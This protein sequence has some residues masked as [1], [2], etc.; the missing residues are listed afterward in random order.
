MGKM[1]LSVGMPRAG[2]GWYYNLTQDLIIAEGGID[3]KEIRSKYNLKRLLTEVNCNLGTLSFYRLIPALM[4]I[5]F[6]PSYV[7]KLH[8]E[9]RPLADLFIKL[10]VIKPTYIYRDPRDA[11]LSAYEYGQRMSKK[12]LQ[13]AFTPLTTIEKAIEFMT[14][15]I[16][17]ATG[18]LNSKQTLSVKYEELKQNYHHE[19]SRLGDFMSID[20]TRD[21]VK[22]VI[23]KYQPGDKPQHHPGLHFVKGTVGRHKE[24]FTESQLALCEQYFGAFLSEHGYDG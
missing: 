10:G 1:I 24:F 17:V 13:N 18:W 19:I 2:S 3:A 20:L 8:A 7:L 15:Y 6:E 11:A 4:P 9:R 16:E 5:F 22:E 21:N 23:E 14:F 12:G